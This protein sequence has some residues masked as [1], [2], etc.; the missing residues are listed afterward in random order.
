MKK[1]YWFLLICLVIILA[2]NHFKTSA[3]DKAIDKN[4]SD[5]SKEESFVEQINLNSLKTP[6]VVETHSLKLKENPIDQP[7][8][9]H[10]ERIVYCKVS[11]EELCLPKKFFI[12]EDE[13]LINQIFL[14]SKYGI[15]STAPKW[16][17]EFEK[18]DRNWNLMTGGVPDFESAP[19]HADISISCD[20]YESNCENEAKEH[21]LVEYQNLLNY[22]TPEE[23]LSYLKEQN[24]NLNDEKIDNISKELNSKFENYEFIS[25][26]GFK[27]EN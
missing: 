15:P 21:S 2:I 10:V 24:L 26:T 22:W 25:E 11:R 12:K 13:D 3:I 20:T 8:F 6:K 18:L 17:K 4:L 7:I 16:D 1:S 27:E 23:V 19:K 9:S 14:T 5:L